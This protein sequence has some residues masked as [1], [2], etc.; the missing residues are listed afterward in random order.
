[1]LN[2]PDKKSAT[3]LFGSYYRFLPYGFKQAISCCK[4]SLFYHPFSDLANF[5]F[6]IWRFFVL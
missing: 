2:S 1:M 6:M 4:A 5:H 3:I